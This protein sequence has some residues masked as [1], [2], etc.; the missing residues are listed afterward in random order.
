MEKKE[1][2]VVLGWETAMLITKRRQVREAFVV[3]VFFVMS[4]VMWRGIEVAS[5]QSLAATQETL[6]DLRE[7]VGAG[8]AQVDALR[9][10]LD[11]VQ[12]SQAAMAAS[13]NELARSI[14]T[15]SGIGQG[16]GAIGAVM[17]V[18]QSL[19]LIQKRR[20]RRAD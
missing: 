18:L 10:D 9:K 7:R 2:G 17:V 1:S 20:E 8:E 14:N 6:G 16:I 3:M 13:V 5:S 4:V 19:N 11:R 15:M 12:A